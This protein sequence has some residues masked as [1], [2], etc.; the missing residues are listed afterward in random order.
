MKKFDWIQ[1]LQESVKIMKSTPTP[2]K[3]LPQ[4]I[5]KPCR[6]ATL[7]MG[8]KT[9]QKPS[10]IYTVWVDDLWFQ[11][12]QPMGFGRVYFPSSRVSL[13]GLPILIH[14]IKGSHSTL[15]H[16][17]SQIRTLAPRP[18][19]FATK[20]VASVDA[21]TEVES[22]LCFGVRCSQ[23]AEKTNARWRPHEQRWT[24]L[25]LGTL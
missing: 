2:S 21:W 22:V 9:K 16:V 23:R 20:H 17:P 10:A 11:Q 19:T 5:P 8:L 13:Q 15:L 7:C 14:S 6:A 1:L 18:K 24:P 3:T 12:S 25:L 4:I